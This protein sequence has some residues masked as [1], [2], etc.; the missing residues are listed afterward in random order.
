MIN[1]L[2][3]LLYNALVSTYTIIL[4]TEIA[5]G[6]KLTPRRRR[7]ENFVAVEALSAKNTGGTTL[8]YCSYLSNA[9]ED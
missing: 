5:N 8:R 7:R 4:C 2:K 3:I 9:G 6:A 1:W